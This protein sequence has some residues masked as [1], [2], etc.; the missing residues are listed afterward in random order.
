MNV[1]KH[2]RASNVR[3]HVTFS[4]DGIDLEVVDDGAGFADDGAPR[5]GFGLFSL[6]ERLEAL[7]GSLVVLSTVGK[8]TRATAKVR[9]TPSQARGN[10][11]AAS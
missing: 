8:G 11:R 3:V 1:I 10:E 5:S 2:S 6:R 4:I 9:R 7:G